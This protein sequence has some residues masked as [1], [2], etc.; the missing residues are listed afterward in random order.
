MLSQLQQQSLFI[1][2]PVIPLNVGAANPAVTVFGQALRDPT[3]GR[4]TTAMPLHMLTLLMYRDGW[5]DGQRHPLK[6]QRILRGPHHLT[7]CPHHQHGGQVVLSRLQ[8]SEK[9]FP[10]GRPALSQMPDIRIRWRRFA[11]LTQPGPGL[12]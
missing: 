2:S 6:G 9:R 4:S 8:F 10:A 3:Y 1:D 7:A 11:R 12:V 5:G